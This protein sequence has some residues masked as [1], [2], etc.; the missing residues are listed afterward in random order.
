M[1]NLFINYYKNEKRF[2]EV[3]ACLQANI[4]N[5]L[6]DRII[7]LAE[8]DFPISSDK[9]IEIPLVERPSYQDFFD[10][11]KDYSDDFNI[12]S[13]LDIAFDSSLIGIKNLNDNTCYAITRHEY[14]NGDIRSFT[15]AN[16]GCPPHFSQDVW[17]F[18]GSVKTKDCHKIL[19]QNEQTKQYEHIKFT[20]GVPGCDNCIAFY[21]MKSYRVKNPYS[22]IKCLHYHCDT[23]RPRY[24]HRM[25]GISTRWG[26]ITRVPESGL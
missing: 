12:I 21:L 9:V 11:T 5:P 10:L 13:N 15:A 19:A 22:D 2:E 16:K 3:K 20:M 17:M 26:I 6:I 18:K 25:T 24:S 7:V 14:C 8:D 1:I 23:G 4:D